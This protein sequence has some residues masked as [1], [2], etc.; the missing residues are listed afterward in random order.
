MTGR[1]IVVT[2]VRE[3]IQDGKTVRQTSEACGVSQETIRRRMRDLGVRRVAPRARKGRPKMT[4]VLNALREGCR[5]APEIASKIGRT[6]NYV[7]VTLLAA[8]NL[9]L[10]SRVGKSSAPRKSGQPPIVWRTIEAPR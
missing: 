6:P 1:K 7:T 5:T 2:G 4:V 3:L 9:G 8:E 10:A